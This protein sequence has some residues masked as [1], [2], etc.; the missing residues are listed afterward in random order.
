MLNFNDWGSFYDFSDSNENSRD[1]RTSILREFMLTVINGP[2]T[3]EMQ[4][5]SHFG[6]GFMM[7][8]G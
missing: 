6:L 8:I 5:L 1:L 3:R 4:L 2:G 7:L